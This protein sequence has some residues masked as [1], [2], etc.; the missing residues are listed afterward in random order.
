MRVDVRY[1]AAD[2]ELAWRG[3]GVAGPDGTARVRV[4]YATDAPNGDGLATGAASWS[5]GER[6]GR[7]RIPERAVVAGSVVR[8]G[9]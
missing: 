5:L 4:P 1:P 8:I 2:R 7:V 9:T 3:E 6:T